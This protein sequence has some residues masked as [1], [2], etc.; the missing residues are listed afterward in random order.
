MVTTDEGRVLQ[1]LDRDQM[2]EI[3]TKVSATNCAIKLSNK[4]LVC[5]QPSFLTGLVIAFAQSRYVRVFSSRDKFLIVLS[6]S[7]DT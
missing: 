6:D 4:S 7:V 1:W 2:A 5:H 3:A